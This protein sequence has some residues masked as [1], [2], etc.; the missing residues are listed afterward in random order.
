MLQVL[1]ADRS[2]SESLCSELLPLSIGSYGCD[3]LATDLDELAGFAA[4]GIKGNEEFIGW[5]DLFNKY[6]QYVI[7][8]VLLACL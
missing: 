4:S 2:E 3:G 6:P 1:G 8:E 5:F 7:M